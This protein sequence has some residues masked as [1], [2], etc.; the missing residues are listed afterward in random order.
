VRYINRNGATDYF[1][2]SLAENEALDIKTSTFTDSEG[3][4]SVYAREAEHMFMAYSNYVTEEESKGLRDLWVS[5]LVEVW[6]NNSFQ[7]IILDNKKVKVLRKKE[8]G[9]IQY[10]LSYYYA[11]NFNIQK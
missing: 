10:A 8:S 3:K 7:S 2:F 11:E 9:L 5:S 6:K 4:Q 1:N